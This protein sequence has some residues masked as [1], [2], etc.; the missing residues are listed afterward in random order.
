MPT[1]NIQD[2][3]AN[4]TEENVHTL[5][6][7]FI[8]ITNSVTLRGAE[9]DFGDCKTLHGVENDTFNMDII[10]VLGD[11]DFENEGEIVPRGRI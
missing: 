7:S 1:D 10:F 9:T 2:D 11:G 3:L 6:T 5:G 4:E 8:I